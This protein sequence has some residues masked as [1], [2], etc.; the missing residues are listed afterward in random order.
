MCAMRSLTEQEQI[1]IAAALTKGR[2][3]LLFLF[4][5]YTGFRIHELLS[6][7]LRDL[8]RDNNIAPTVTI[9]RRLLK[10]GAGAHPR[11]VRSRT[12]ILHPALRAALGSHVWERFGNEPVSGDD[13]L[14]RSRKG[15]NRPI[16]V[17][18]AWEIIKTAARTLGYADRVA[19]HSMRK[20]FA[21]AVYDNSGHDLILTQKA[22][23]HRAVSS[24]SSYLESTD[25]EVSQAVLRFS[26]PAVPLRENSKDAGVRHTNI[27]QRLASGG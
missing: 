9:P 8:W 24:T 5:I 1:D 6:L 15:P 26:G 7:R 10:G 17:G 11:R 3:R 14:F 22:L 23:G 21:R 18:H 2:D 4:G 16:T 19:T 27:E 13:Y 12:A 20:T 25:E